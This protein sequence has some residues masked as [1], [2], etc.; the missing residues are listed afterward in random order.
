M[1]KRLFISWILLIFIFAS[2]GCMSEESSSKE[3]AFSLEIGSKT[4]NLGSEY[5]KEIFGSELEYS[6]IASCAFEGLDKTYR[7]Q[8]YEVTTY[9]IDGVDKIASIYFLDDTISTKEGIKITDSYEKM[10]EIYG[11]NY[12][13][14]GIQYTYTLG[15]T[16]LIFLIE[17]GFI[18]S[19]EYLLNV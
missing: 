10:V 5:Q 13:K 1:K 18:T 12:Q 15:K 7:F 8:N 4:I 9:P 2:V 16:S 3:E 6:E 17:N 19:I 11:N 14:E